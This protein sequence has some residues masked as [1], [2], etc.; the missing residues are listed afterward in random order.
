[1]F[2]SYLL[3]DPAFWLFATLYVVSVLFASFLLVAPQWKFVKRPEILHSLPRFVPYL[4]T[5]LLIYQ[6]FHQAEHV[7]QMYQFA[8]LGFRAADAHGFVWFFDLEWNH[9][10]FNFGYMIGVSIVL[11]AILRALK[12]NGLGYSF[13]H[14]WAIFAFLIMEAWHLVEHTYRL[15]HHIRGICDSCPGIIDTVTG[16]DRLLLHFWLNFFALTLPAAVYIWF[17]LYKKVI[18][19][20]VRAKCKDCG[21]RLVSYSCDCAGYSH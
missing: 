9:F 11:C 12:K 4:F 8:F 16:V 5:G 17:G 14:T 7:T 2:P 20:A 13:A 21:S 6:F 10:I 3:T 15:S 19:H 18:P 1:M